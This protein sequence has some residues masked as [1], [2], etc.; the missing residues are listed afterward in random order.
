M[1]KTWKEFS[2]KGSCMKKKLNLKI[3]MYDGEVNKKNQ[4][5]GKGVL[6]NPSEFTKYIGEFINGKKNGKGT[7]K[8]LEEI[9]SQYSEINKNL[10]KDYVVAPIHNPPSMLEYIGEFKD[11]KYEGFGTE[12]YSNG[13]KYVGEFKNSKKHG[14]GTYTWG[15]GHKY[16]GDWKNDNKH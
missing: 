12:T 11:D 5:H 2:S 10:P 7:L 6:S 16:I 1:E 13:D 8:Y 9:R 4:P 14:K 15:E 3:G